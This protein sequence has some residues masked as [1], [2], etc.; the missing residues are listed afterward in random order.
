MAVES[1]TGFEDEQEWLLEAPRTP[2]AV[3]V[4]YSRTDDAGRLEQAHSR[5]TVPAHCT[6]LQLQE[7][8]LDE[9]GLSPRQPIELRLWGV[10]LEP[11]KMLKDLRI[12]DCTDGLRL[13]MI[14]RPAVASIPSSGPLTRLRVKSHKLQMPITV[15]GLA[16]DT[17]VAE[18]KRLLAT[19]LARSPI[20]MAPEERESDERTGSMALRKGDQLTL[21]GEAA[22]GKKGVM[23]VRRARDGE[24]G[25]VTEA[26]VTELPITQE[27]MSLLFEGEALANET[28]LSK[29]QLINN[30]VLYLDFPWPWESAEDDKKGG[31][32]KKESGGK[33]K[34]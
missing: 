27:V 18:F 13:I 14:K 9:L 6:V 3:R 12:K 26:D 7:L 2:R 21:D 25:C 10:V 33:K 29:Y 28:P 31:G 32:G 34:K 24:M 8:L 1:R 11:S 4:R 23:R 22:D 19:Q 16:G 20:Y 15:E 17:V 5:V 30:D